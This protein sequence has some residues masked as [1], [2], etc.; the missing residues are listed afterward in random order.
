MR[1]YLRA[2]TYF[3]DDLPLILASLAFIAFSTLAGL[4]QPFTVKILTDTVFASKPS[5]YWVNRVFVVIANK[6][7]ASSPAQQVMI[8]ACMAV[9][10]RVIQEILG[11]GQRLLTQ[12]IGYNGVLRVRCDLFR[13]LQSLSIG[14]HKSQPQG[15]AIYRLSYDAFGFQTIFNAL[16]GNVLVSSVTLILMVALM[17]RMNVI[18]TLLTLSVAPLLLITTKLFAGPMKRRWLEAKEVETNLTTVMQRSVASIGLVQAFGRETDEYNR[19]Q[20]TAQGTVRANLRQAWQ[21]SWYWLFVGAIFGT[22]SALIIWYWGHCYIRG[23]LQIG[24][25]WIY[26]S[27]VSMVYAPLQSV[28]SSAASLQA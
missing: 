1:F 13:K 5:P 12:L 10:L 17:I 23:T 24:D 3:R 8:V 15:D 7:G 16:T 6:I 21:E 9:G 28:S 14:Y 11:M 18:M 19:F 22:G 27:F 20:S 2:L 26:M 4:L 25:L